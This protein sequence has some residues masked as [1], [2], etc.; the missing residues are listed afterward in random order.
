MMG[1]RSR[2]V[3]SIFIFIGWLVF[4]LIHAAFWARGFDLFQNI[5]IVLVSFLIA[6]GVLGAMWAS[7][8]MRFIR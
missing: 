4:I 7:W 2:V 5:V 1:I 3:A 8:G 6:G